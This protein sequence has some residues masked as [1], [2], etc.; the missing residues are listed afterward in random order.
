MAEVPFGPHLNYWIVGKLLERNKMIEPGWMNNCFFP[1]NFS[2]DHCNI[3]PKASMKWE[4]ILNV[5]FFR[6]RY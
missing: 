3:C 1:S 6:D 5:P 4:T 2:S